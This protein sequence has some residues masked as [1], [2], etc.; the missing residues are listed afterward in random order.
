[1]SAT[2]AEGPPMRLDKDGTPHTSAH[3]AITASE[4][5]SAIPASEFWS[6]EFKSEFKQGSLEHDNHSAKYTFKVLGAT[7]SKSEWD[8]SDAE[9]DRFLAP[10]LAWAKEQYPVDVIDTKMAGV[11]I[12]RITPKDGV[13]PENEH[14]ILINL[15]GGGF[16]LGRGLVMGQIE[17]IPLASIGK[18]EVVTVDYRQAPY[19]KF[20]AGTEDVEAVYKELLKQYKSE[21][22]GIFGTSAGGVLTAQAVVGIESKGLPRPGAVGIFWAGPGPFWSPLFCKQGDSMMWVRG[23]R[24]EN[25]ARGVPKQYI[26]N[27]M[28]GAD[29]NDPLANPGSSDAA[30]AKFPP[31]LFITGTR[32]FDMSPA[33][34]AHARLLKLDVDS[35]LYIMEGGWHAVDLYVRGTPE[36][37]DV[38]TYKVS[39]FNRHLAR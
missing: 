11:H 5:W 30:L 21:A 3:R 4:L 15:H 38:D 29:A 16:Y 24:R 1:V 32:A 25:A 33:I 22:I 34:V 9:Y 26:S 35:S 13:A 27:Y 10:Y 28:E 31:T 36:K 18:I 8:K 12:G 7:A 2:L 37:R 20:P 14:R 19:F 17:S 6:S 39:W 23:L